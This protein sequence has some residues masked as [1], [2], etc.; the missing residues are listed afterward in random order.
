[1][2]TDTDSDLDMDIDMDDDDE[3]EDKSSSTKGSQGAFSDS[4][5]HTLLSLYRKGMTGWGKQKTPFIDMAIQQTGLQ[6]SQIQVL[7]NK[8][9]SYNR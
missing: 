4:V 9:C 2:S 7:H 1:M 5:K 3:A 8:F 6:M